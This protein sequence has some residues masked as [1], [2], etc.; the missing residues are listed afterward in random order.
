MEKFREKVFKLKFENGDFYEGEIVN[1]RFD[2]IGI[3]RKANGDIF[4]GTFKEN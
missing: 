1:N 4:E 3:Y 2:G